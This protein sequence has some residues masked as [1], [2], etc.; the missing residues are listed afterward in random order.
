MIAPRYSLV[1]L[2]DNVSF[3]QSARFGYLGTVYSALRKAN[4][5]AG[6]TLLVNG[7]TGTLG[8]GG[9]L[10]GLAMG[11]PRILGTGRNRQLL[12]RVR[13]LAPRRIEIFSLDD[14]P[15]D[16]WALQQTEG[17]GVDVYLDCLGPGAPPSS[18][19]EG[20]KSLARGATAVNIGAMKGAIP[21]DIRVL[22]DCNQR[23]IGSAWFTAAEG[24]DMAALARAG[25]LDLSVFE[26]IRH[27]LANINEAI[28]GI[29][30]RNGG[31]SNFV[32]VP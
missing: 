7:I 14:G 27:P 2:P 16:A 32:I 12:E 23:L 25:V 1:K 3:E 17:E 6:T 11:V 26:H 31:F 21:F 10:L 4:A 8:I 28:S 30:Q 24:D 15:L 19:L 13:A 20:F 18:M 5:G 9:A 29:A 22:M